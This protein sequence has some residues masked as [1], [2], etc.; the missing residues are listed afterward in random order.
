MSFWYFQF[1]QKTN[2]KIQLNYYDT[3]DRIVFVRVLE[4]FK[5]PNWHFETNRP[6]IWKIKI[7]HNFWKIFGNRG[8]CA[9]NPATL[10]ASKCLFSNAGDEMRFKLEIT[11]R[12]T[13]DKSTEKLRGLLFWPLSVR[14][15]YE[16]L[17]VKNMGLKW[18]E[19]K[20]WLTP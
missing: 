13:S 8:H 16:M 15:I 9:S 19:D 10:K 6:F 20:I 17:G 14:T 4:E 18:V 3:S 5:T 2:E 12:L 7:N 11:I 1:L